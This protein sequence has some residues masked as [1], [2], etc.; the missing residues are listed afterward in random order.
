MKQVGKLYLTHGTPRTVKP[1]NGQQ[2]STREMEWL[3]GGP[4]KKIPNT[5][6]PGCRSAFHAAEPAALPENDMAS[7]AFKT[8][9]RGN[10]V[11]ILEVKADGVT[12][13]V[14]A[15]QAGHNKPAAPK[16]VSASGQELTKTPWWRKKAG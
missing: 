8:D 16:S 4:F 13:V 11:Q 2:F 5:G 12:P 15:A 1:K 3:L 10:V 9:L 14:A 6:E 7:K